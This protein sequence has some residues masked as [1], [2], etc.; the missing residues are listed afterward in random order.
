MYY[1]KFIH[2][3]TDYSDGKVHIMFELDAVS[4][5]SFSFAPFHFYITLESF[6]LSEW[7]FG[8]R[9]GADAQSFRD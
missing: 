1:P 3:L 5:L 7:F 4:G 8:G 9:C 6:R 2:P